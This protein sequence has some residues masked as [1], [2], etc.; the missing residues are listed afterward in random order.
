MSAACDCI[1]VFG[2]GIND[3]IENT[4]DEAVVCQ[5]LG[6]RLAVHKRAIRLGGRNAGRIAHV[7]F[8]RI[9]DIEVDGI[10]GFSSKPGCAGA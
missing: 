5:G 7:I 9:V 1:R 3:G 4:V 10:H 6:I 8:E 2:D